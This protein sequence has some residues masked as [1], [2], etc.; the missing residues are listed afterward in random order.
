MGENKAFKGKRKQ[1][2]GSP[3]F[4]TTQGRPSRS[5]LAGKKGAWKG[6]E[7]KHTGF[8]NTGV[9]RDPE[10]GQLSLGTGNVTLREGDNKRKK[11]LEKGR[12]RN[13]EK[14]SRVPGVRKRSHEL[15]NIKT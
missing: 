7:R 8:L 12:R 14:R 4:N 9:Q 13:R 10:G 11:V 2:G 3:S 6:G 1:K 5:N 15:L